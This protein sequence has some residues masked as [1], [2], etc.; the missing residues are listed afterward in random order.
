MANRFQDIAT[1]TAFYF[2]G[3]RQI[4][5][6]CIK[7]EPYAGLHLNEYLR[8]KVHEFGFVPLAGQYAGRL[9]VGN[10]FSDTETVEIC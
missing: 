10:I 3:E 9:F 4:H 6:K 8:D 7:V 1:G 2:R 5:G